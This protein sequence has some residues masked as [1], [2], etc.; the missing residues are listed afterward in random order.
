M[1]RS[2]TLII[3]HYHLLRGGVTSAVLGSLA[4]LASSG[5][6]E[7][8]RIRLLVGRDE[9]VAA[10][11]E[12]PFLKSLDVA[13]AVH[14][15]LD[16]RDDSWPDE[17]RYREDVRRLTRWLLEQ[18]RGETLFWLHNATLGKNPLVTAAWR[19]ATEEAARRNLPFRFLYHIHDFAECGRLQNLERLARCW[20]T[21]GLSVLYPENETSA[22]AV[23]NTADENRLKAA[24]VPPER[25]FL[26]P[27][28][29]RVPR[30]PSGPQA[31]RASIA[32]ALERFARL[33]GFR[34][35]PSRPWWLLPIRMIRRKN[36]LEA[37]LLEA[38]APEPCQV[39]V[40]LEG[41]SVRER[42]YSDAVV[43]LAAAAGSF[44]TA[45][46][47]RDLVGTAF[48]LSDLYRAS[49]CC[50]TTS[51]LEGFGFAFLDGPMQGCPIFGRNLPDVTEDFRVTGLPLEAF[52]PTLEVPVREETRKRLV[53]AAS[54]FA[55]R[56]QANLR[57]DPEIVARF[58]KE[59]D[60]VFTREWVDFGDLD[61]EAQREVLAMAG[62]A[63]FI[64]ELRELNPG[65]PNPAAIP[66]DF[67]ARAEAHF[68]PKAH[69]A[70]LAGAFDG[71][72]SEKG[73][74]W[75]GRRVGKKLLQ[76]FFQLRY[77]R[78]LFG[79]WS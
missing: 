76:S 4:A 73:P 67:E 68:G 6:L 66:S 27:N 14:P 9:G 22:F 23:L 35:D 34:F 28:V 20:T 48:S 17:N 65:V 43:E 38:M 49:Q 44:F 24:G 46:F 69:A 36:V 37:L 5:W 13:V 64:A 12:A 47:G 31:S 54:A 52:Y 60:A 58:R 8:R 59:V 11:L 10:F 78:P 63:G 1:K 77:Q 50:V 42:P 19:E 71:L 26:I 53:K 33:K 75:D 74:T 56:Q 70:R 45:G 51:L 21:G 41:E 7:G 3:F 79:G 15:G 39:L 29:V 61:F 32:G 16:Y 57:L 72:F 40:T 30:T 2:E 62:D 18:A 55:S 25:V